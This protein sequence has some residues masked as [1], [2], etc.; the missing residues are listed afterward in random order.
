MGWDERCPP[1]KAKIPPAMTF[2][3]LATDLYPSL[4][5]IL[6]KAPKR[7]R[8]KKNKTVS[9]FLKQPTSSKGHTDLVSAG[10]SLPKRGGGVSQPPFPAAGCSK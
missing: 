7:E 9:G 5:L 4:N 8:D 1:K 6:S 10:T 2:W 3:Y